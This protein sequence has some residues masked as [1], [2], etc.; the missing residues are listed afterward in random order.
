MQRVGIRRSGLIM[1]MVG[2][3]L[4]ATVPGVSATTPRAMWVWS[5]PEAEVL[6]FASAHG[7]TDLYLH[8]PPGFSSDPAYADFLSGAVDIGVGV[9]AMAGDPAWAKKSSDMVAWVDEVVEAGGFVGIVA[10]VE[11]Y[12]RSE[13]SNARRRTRLVRSY[14]AGLEKAEARAGSLPFKAAVPFWWDLPE[15]SVSDVT[16]VEDVLNRV[17]GVVV[18][19]YRDHALGVDGIVDLASTEVSLA[20]SLGKTAV[21]GVE[22]GPLSLDKVTFIEEGSSFMEAELSL[23]ELAFAGEAAFGGMAVHHYG[24]WIS[25]A[26]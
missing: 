11:P 9:H 3:S 19:A 5:G 24:S 25:L 13:W 26:P 14:L 8:A 1:G 4:L 17:D 12:L 7:V 20:S 21:V 23:V 6:D 18:M 15:F 10:D 16:L 22:T 2:L